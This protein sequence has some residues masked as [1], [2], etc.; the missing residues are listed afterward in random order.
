[1]AK[2]HVKSRCQ[3]G[4]NR[5][6]RPV[7]LQ[8]WEDDAMTHTIDAVYSGALGINRAALEY[9][10]PPTTLKDQI[11]RRVVHG[12]KMGAKHIIIANEDQLTKKSKNYIVHFLINCSKMGYGKTTKDILSTVKAILMRKAEE[13]QKKFLENV[14]QG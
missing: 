5:V 13:E 10:M 11:T 6:N 9:G 4:E 1:M 2:N 14:L 8:I 3:S 7:K 12:T